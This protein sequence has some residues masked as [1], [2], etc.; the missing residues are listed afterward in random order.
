M[1]IVVF[2]Q[3]KEEI[4]EQINQTGLEIV[5]TKPEAVI[6]YGGDGTLILSEFH[7]P[8]IPKL[9]LRG[10]SVCKLCSVKNNQAVLAQLARGA[11][12]IK[13]V[14]KLEAK[15]NAGK[16]LAIND[17]ILHNADPR[18]AIRY[19]VSIS[20]HPSS[21][22]DIIGDGVVVATTLGAS[23]YYK[24]I[25]DSVFRVGIGL[26]FN[27]STEQADHLV[28]TTDSIITL[29][30]TRGPAMLY[31]DNQPEAISLNKGDVITIKKASE[32]A[33]IIVVD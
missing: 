19:R 12:K 5:E 32:G 4:Y 10:S 18:H 23:G 2:S 29:T 24:S 15:T 31:A 22:Q 21:E 20:D 1:R 6:S 33:K 13:E 28:L 27:N 16:L 11:F 17:I 25:T 14:I 3:K 7:Y 30:I 8:S 26:A 9:P